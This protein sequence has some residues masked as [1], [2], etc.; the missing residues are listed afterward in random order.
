MECNPQKT[1]Q[2]KVSPFVF[3]RQCKLSAQDYGDPEYD[4]S[5][6]KPEPDQSDGSDV[7]QGNLGGTYQ[8]YVSFGW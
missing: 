5:H 1:E 8:N 2:S 4:N 3:I 6:R 7:L